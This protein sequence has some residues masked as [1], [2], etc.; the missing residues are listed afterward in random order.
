MV[1]QRS[2]AGPAPVAPLSS[3]RPGCGPAPARGL[4]G[5]ASPG[6]AVPIPQCRHVQGDP[7][8]DHAARP[9]SQ[10]DPECAMTAPL[11]IEV[12]EHVVVNGVAAEVMP[13]RCGRWHFRC[14]QVLPVN[15]RHWHGPYA[16]RQAALDDLGQRTA[17][18][19]LTRRQVEAKAPP[20]LPG[21]LRR[22]AGDP[23]PVPPDRRHR[24]HAVRAG[25]GSGAM[26][27]GRAAPAPSSL[28]AS[29]AATRTQPGTPVQH[30]PS[31]RSKP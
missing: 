4:P 12:P 3:P 5:P 23:A 24:A 10:H 21:Q 25:R 19:A 18:P 11:D 31:S 29:I 13:F 20:R 26:T 30:S 27:R 6:H 1:A 9:A 28:D 17:L 16:D 2:R 8:A 14:P 15:A 22:R 7:H